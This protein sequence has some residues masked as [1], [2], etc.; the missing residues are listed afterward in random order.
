M[1]YS[2]GIFSGK[3]TLVCSAS[4]VVVGHKCDYKGRKPVEDRIGVI[5]HWEKCNNLSEVHSFLGVTGVL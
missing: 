3:K 1:K 2:G 4:I 5:L